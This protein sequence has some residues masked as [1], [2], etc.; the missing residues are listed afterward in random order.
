M[1]VSVRSHLAAGAA[2]S[3][4]AFSPVAPPMPDLKVPGL[5][6]AAVELSA[7]A[8]PIE[9]FAT[10]FQHAF[11]NAESLGQIIAANPAPILNAIL[12]NQVSS[13]E[14]LAQVARLVGDGLSTEFTT[15]VP[16]QLQ[17]A[18][19]DIAAGDITQG[20]TTA[21]EAVLGAVVAAALPLVFSPLGEQ[22]G[23]IVQNPFENLSNVVNTVTDPLQVLGAVL[24]PVGLI[25]GTINVVGPTAEAALGAAE[26]PEAFANAVLSFVPALTDALLN[27]ESSGLLAPYSGLAANLLALQAAVA[28]AIDPLVPSTTLRTNLPAANETAIDGA[29]T[30]TVSVAENDPTSK[31]EAPVASKV[32]PVPTSTQEHGSEQTGEVKPN[33]ATKRANPVKD[34]REG[35][36]GALNGARNGLRN[37]TESLGGKSANPVKSAVSDSKDGPSGSTSP[38][39][40]A[41]SG[42]E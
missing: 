12:S 4:V 25:Q 33:S 24:A 30:F 17:T 21:F 18:L 35:I 8:N 10:A 7:L 26:D 38:N 36:K 27:G 19:D 20:L 14:V 39:G 37:A 42:A 34:V 40:G 9:E 15:T 6:S 22:F 5:S 11:V 16:E 1:Q 2:V 28:N 31:P 29:S 32:D 13:V 23:G 41:S 3:A